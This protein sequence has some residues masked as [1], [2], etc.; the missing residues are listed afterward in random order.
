MELGNMKVVNIVEKMVFDTMDE[1]LEHKPDICKCDKCL[2]D[3]VAYALNK[4]PPR[5]VASEKG[6]TIAKAAYLEKTIQVALLVAV[7]E[8]VEQISAHPRHEKE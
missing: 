2:A 1:V 5:Y 8:A 7:T 3:I 6:G 4:L